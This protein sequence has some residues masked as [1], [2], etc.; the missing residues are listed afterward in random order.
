MSEADRIVS[1]KTVLVTSKGGF[2]YAKE[3][4]ITA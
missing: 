2:N 4:S 1:Y 3:T